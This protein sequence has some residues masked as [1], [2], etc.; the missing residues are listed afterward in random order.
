MRIITSTFYES[1]DVIRPIRDA[2][3]GREQGVPR[4]LDWDGLDPDCVHAV[5]LDEGGLPVGTG[6]MLPDGRIGRLAVLE[7][8]RGRGIG[9]RILC[10]LV[11]KARE[12]G[13]ACVYVHAQIQTVAFYEKHGFRTDAGEFVEA[14]IRHVSMIKQLR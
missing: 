11:E 10:E 9:G 6:R 7:R 13:L 2:V 12:Q 1:A 4:E 5:V 14:G 8:F 3:F